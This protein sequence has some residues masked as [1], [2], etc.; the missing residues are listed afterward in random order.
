MRFDSRYE[1]WDHE[2]TQPTLEPLRLTHCP[3][4]EPGGDKCVLHCV[5]GQ[6]VVAEDQPGD[7]EEPVE[8]VRRELLE[9]PV[10]AVP[11]PENEIVGQ[12]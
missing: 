2:A 10:V 12:G 6:L 8:G 5:G 4:M 7:T 1:A 9:C 11:S 3:D